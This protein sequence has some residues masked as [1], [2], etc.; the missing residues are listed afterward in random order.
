MPELPEVETVRRT[1]EPV[2][3][4]KTIERCEIYYQRLLQ[5][6]ASQFCGQVRNRTIREIVRRGKYLIIDLNGELELIVHL[7]MTGQLIH[8]PTQDLPLQNTFQPVFGSGITAN[9]ALLISAVRDHV[10]DAERRLP[11]NPRFVPLNT[12]P[13]LADGFTWHV[14][15]EKLN[16]CG[17]SRPFCLTR[18]KLPV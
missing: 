7:R 6:G 9:C 11:R 14:L 18:L 5:A 8:K 16:P 17:L 12:Q 2:I 3:V 4:G 1:L 15:A 10:F 13:N